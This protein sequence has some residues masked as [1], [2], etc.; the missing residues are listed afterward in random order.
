MKVD[1]AKGPIGTKNAQEALTIA[2]KSPEGKRFLEGQEDGPII[3]RDKHRG[4]IIV[5]FC[6]G[7]DL[8]QQSISSDGVEVVIESDKGSSPS[9]RVAISNEDRPVNGDWELLSV[10]NNHYDGEYFENGESDL[11][12]LYDGRYVMSV[13]L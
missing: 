5:L 6:I 2:G 12:C 9:C 8:I 4:Q 13:E 10:Q 11:G 3:L 7:G 1:R